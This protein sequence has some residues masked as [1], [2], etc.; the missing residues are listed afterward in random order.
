MT[1]LLYLSNISILSIGVLFLSSLLIASHPIFSVQSQNSTS[2]QNITNSFYIP[3]TI[4]PEAQDM[5]KNMTMST[6]TLVTPNPEDIKRWQ[7]LNQQISSLLTEMSQ[8]IVDMYKPNVTTTKLGNVTVLD[9]KPRD[10]RDNDKV[11]VYLHGGGHTLLSANSTLGLTV[12]VANSTGLRIISVDYSLAPISK[13]N[14]TTNEVLSVIQALVQEQGFSTEDIVIF[15]DS[16]GGGLAVGSVLKMRD[17]GI[18]IPAAIVLWSPWVDATGKGDTY[19]TLKNA[20]PITSANLT[21]KNMADAYA[22]PSDQENPYVS[23][24]YGNF[25]KGFPP[26]LIQGGTKD[27]LLSDFVRLYQA[28]DKAGIPVKLDIYEGMPHD[29]PFVL[30]GTPESNLALSKTNDFL[31]E[32]LSN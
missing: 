7:N 28:I 25:S 20:D 9:I 17:E 6:S 19:V 29:F 13:W 8:P 24:V 11:L 4:S 15:G 32:H 16:A 21:L 27:I 5:L 1:Q 26:T 3:S 31:M 10:W 30:F 23:P 14:Q 12:P 22:N 2:S 18:G